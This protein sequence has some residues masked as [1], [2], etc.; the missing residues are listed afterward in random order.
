MSSFT[1]SDRGVLSLN[2][3]PNYEDDVGLGSGKTYTVVVVASDDAPGAGIDPG[4]ED[5]IRTSMK[6]VTVTVEDVEEPGAITT[7]PKNPHVAFP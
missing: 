5:P 6:T 4:E 7:S 3:S 2:A 1:I